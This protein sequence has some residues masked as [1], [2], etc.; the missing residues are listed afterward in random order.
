M[1]WLY[2]GGLTAACL[3]NR[4]WIFGSRV[5]IVLRSMGE[6][7]QH[8]GDSN[9]GYAPDSD[10]RQLISKA[11][12]HADAYW[13]LSPEIS[14]LYESIGVS[15]GKIFEI[16]NIV[17]RPDISDL[18]RVCEKIRVGVIGRNHRKKNFDLL[19]EII[20]LLPPD[21][22][23]FHLKISGGIPN[24][25]DSNIV[26]HQ[27]SVVRHLLYWPPDDVWEFYAGINVLLV[28]SRV[29]SFGNV[30]FEA[31]LTGAV[32]VINEETT[33]AELA[34]KCGIKVQTFK[35]FTAL[36]ISQILQAQDWPR[37]VGALDSNH[38]NRVEIGRMIM[39][40]VGA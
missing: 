13:A 37:E 20:P 22:F 27:A 36:E 16:G 23:E 17:V 21:R 35:N 34:R 3:L 2:G 32:I 26:V 19:K 40:I 30:T 9:Y 25:D 29:E 7:I 33:G 12:L 24:L 1:I 11:Y 6:D 10:E 18:S 14:E 15:K 4:R 8:D 38:L 5:K 28:L 31:G 39:E